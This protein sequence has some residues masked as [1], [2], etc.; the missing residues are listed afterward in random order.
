[1]SHDFPL[2][3][4]EQRILMFLFC[5]TKHNYDCFVWFSRGNYSNQTIFMNITEKNKWEWICS[6]E[7]YF[8]KIINLSQVLKQDHSSCTPFSAPTRLKPLVC[9]PPAI[10]CLPFPFKSWFSL[11]YRG[12][13]AQEPSCPI[14]APK[15]LHPVWYNLVP[16]HV[17]IATSTCYNH[18][19]CCRHFRCRFCIIIAFI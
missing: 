9:K 15:Q 3:H 8:L 7:S 11:R 14:R 1:M 16:D 13:Q 2:A 12:S 6:D 19:R 18:A 5:V 10:S 4:L 17:Y